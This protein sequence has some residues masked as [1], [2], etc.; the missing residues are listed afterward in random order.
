MYELEAL[1]GIDEATFVRVLEPLR[2]QVKAHGLWAAHLP[3]ELGGQGY[4]SLKLG[5]LSEIIGRSSFGPTV[6]G[7]QAPDAGNAELIAATGTEEQKE[8]WLD[9]LLDRRRQK[10]LL[11]DRAGYGRLGPDASRHPRRS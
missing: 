8:R 4:G 6:F 10:C 3:P 7:S 2:D 11:D 1:E 5:L 9:P